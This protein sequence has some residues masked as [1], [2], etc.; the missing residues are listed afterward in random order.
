MIC[1]S[2]PKFEPSQ[3]IS[4]QR[5]PKPS[6]RGVISSQREQ[7]IHPYVLEDIGP[8][9]QLPKNVSE[10]KSY[11]FQNFHIHIQ[12]FTAKRI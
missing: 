10:A 12:K 11:I 2:C 3:P 1:P 8:V 5:G 9:G 6:L 7:E 4:G